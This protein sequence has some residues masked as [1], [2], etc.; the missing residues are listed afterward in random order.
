M[1]KKKFDITKFLFRAFLVIV[2]IYG[3]AYIIYS[4]ITISASTDSGP[5]ASPSIVTTSNPGT[6]PVNTLP[7]T[8]EAEPAGANADTVSNC[9][10]FGDKLN[11]QLFAYCRSEADFR[12][13]S[14][15]TFY[16][17]CAARTSMLDTQV[18][19]F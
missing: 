3:V 7:A 12:R 14:V 2:I 6:S 13:F 18:K 10:V 5:A 19:S 15:R 8:V 17:G 4:I 16:L 11:T 9:P 1:A